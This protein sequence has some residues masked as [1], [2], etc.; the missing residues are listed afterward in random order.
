MCQRDCYIIY[1]KGLSGMSEWK[2]KE[3]WNRKGPG[4]G[5]ILM[6]CSPQELL[7]VRITQ[8]VHVVVI[9][10]LQWQEQES[11]GGTQQQKPVNRVETVSSHMLCLIDT[12]DC[13]RLG[14]QK[15]PPAAPQSCT[16]S[17]IVHR[18]L[19]TCVSSLQL[20]ALLPQFCDLED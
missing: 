3:V 2:R 13:W 15:A 4:N 7:A 6:D 20:T 5:R 1:T 8:V 14:S 16:G 10:D 9:Q 18:C 19:L 11:R 17:V 12:H